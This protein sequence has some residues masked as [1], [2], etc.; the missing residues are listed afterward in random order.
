M[1]FTA[2]PGYP[3]DVRPQT[4]D[5]YKEKAEEILMGSTVEFISSV[6]VFKHVDIFLSILTLVSK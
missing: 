2:V 1:S 3:V 4:L 6:L 5:Y